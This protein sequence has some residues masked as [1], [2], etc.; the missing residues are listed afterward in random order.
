MTQQYVT[1]G[2]QDRQAFDSTKLI[3]SIDGF[4]SLLRDYLEDEIVTL[5]GLC[6]Y[7][8]KLLA[9]KEMSDR[10]GQAPITTRLFGPM[11]FARNLGASMNVTL[12]V[13]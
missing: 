8:D 13:E 3:Q 12:R 2:L 10:D 7:G 9:F 6:K 1:A 4:A 5:A 11:L